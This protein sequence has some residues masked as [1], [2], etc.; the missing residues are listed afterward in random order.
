VENRPLI[1]IDPNGE[2][3]YI[4]Y[5]F[6]GSGLSMAQQNA[7]VNNVYSHYAGGTA[8]KRGSLGKYDARVDI[9]FTSEPIGREGK[10]GGTDIPAQESE[11]TTSRMPPG[12]AGITLLSNVAAH[13][14]GHATH[15]MPDYNF[16]AAK[17]GS[18]WHPR[19]AEEGTLMESQVG[20]DDPELQIRLLSSGPREASDG[21]AAKLRTTLNSPGQ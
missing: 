10:L 21:D 9:S 19:P 1:A 18:F 5:D 2:D 11:V 12:K 6:V 15:A 14:I 16:D 17:K 3:L 7:G 8:P 13:E 20:G 4:V